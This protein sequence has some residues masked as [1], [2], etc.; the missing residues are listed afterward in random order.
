M[1]PRRRPA[2]RRGRAPAD[3]RRRRRGRELRARGGPARRAP[4]HRPRRLRARARSSARSCSPHAHARRADRPA[5]PPRPRP[6]RRPLGRRHRARVAPTASPRWPGSAHD[7]GVV[8]YTLGGGLSWLARKH[9]FACD[10][11]TAIELVTADGR[12]IST[13]ARPRSRAVP[14]AARRRRELRRRDR[15]RVQALPG[16]G[17]HR[18]ARCCGRGSAPWRSST[19]GA[20][21]R[22]LVPDDITSL[23][24]LLQVPALPDV[25]APL[26]GRSFVVIEAA[27][28]GDDAM[29]APLRALEPELDMFAPMPPAGADRDP[30]RPEAADARPRRPP[31]ARRRRPPRRSPRSWAPPGPAGSPLVSVELRHLGGACRSTPLL[32]CSRSASRWTPSRRWRSTPRLARLMAATAPYDAGRALLNFTDQPELGDRF[33]RPTPERCARSRPGWMAATSSPPTTRSLDPLDSNGGS[34]PKTV[35]GSDP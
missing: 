21:G 14:R 2:A 27:I 10:S 20:S 7:V 22:A 34:E 16:R 35:E 29:L 12:L 3:R 9:G 28:L 32:A 18:A 1:E 13:D 30:Q 11:V 24:R 19:P 17:A 4:G 6:R 25:P 8:G 23:C 5:R 31:R 33:L 15:D 26:R